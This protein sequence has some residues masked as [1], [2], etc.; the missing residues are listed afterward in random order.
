MQVWMMAA[1]S[2]GYTLGRIHVNLCLTVVQQA[3]LLALPVS[4]ADRS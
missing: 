1:V 4:L 2:K 3:R